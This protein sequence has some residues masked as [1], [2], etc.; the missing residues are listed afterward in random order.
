MRR[1]RIHIVLGMVLL[2]IGETDNPLGKTQ[3]N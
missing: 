2:L 3:A 1:T